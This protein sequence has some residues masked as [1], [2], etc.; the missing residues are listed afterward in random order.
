[1]SRCGCDA[2]SIG[3]AAA[4][5]AAESAA[6][7]ADA[8]AREFDAAAFLADTHGCEACRPAPGRPAATSEACGFEAEIFA[9]MCDGGAQVEITVSGDAG[10]ALIPPG[11][12]SELLRLT[13]EHGRVRCQAGEVARATRTR[14][15]TFSATP[16]GPWANA[17]ARRCSPPSDTSPAWAR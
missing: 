5:A 9:T 14:R 11:L 10:A 6:A 16:V 2:G 3:A 15:T 4:A 8:D 1:M 12:T 13:R 17:R 7:T